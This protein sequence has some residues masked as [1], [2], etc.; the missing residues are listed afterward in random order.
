MEPVK[1]KV[2]KHDESDRSSPKTNCT[3]AYAKWREELAQK[4]PRERNFCANEKKEIIREL[5]ILSAKLLDLDVVLRLFHRQVYDGK[6]K[7]PPLEISED[8]YDNEAKYGSKLE[9][10]QKYN[11][12]RGTVQSV[13]GTMYWKICY[14]NNNDTCPNE[15]GVNDVYKIS[16]QF[17]KTPEYTMKSPF[18][19]KPLPSKIYW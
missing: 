7:V 18:K 17:R 8:D 12:S 9:R 10:N 6:G 5:E 1:K 2:K 4:A 16:L 13:R 11:G 15:D 14:E 3:D 19:Y